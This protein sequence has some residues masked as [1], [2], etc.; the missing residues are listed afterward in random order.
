MW[1]GSI[2]V[3]PASATVPFRLCWAFSTP[4]AARLSGVYSHVTLHQLFETVN[5][6]DAAV[7]FAPAVPGGRLAGNASTVERELA[8]RTHARLSSNFG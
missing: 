3:S 6:E 7:R 2:W 1:P 8:L 5:L 4:A